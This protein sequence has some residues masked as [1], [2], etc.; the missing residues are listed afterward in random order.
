MALLSCFFLFFGF[1]IWEKKQKSFEIHTPAP[2]KKRHGTLKTSLEK[3]REHINN[4]QQ[5]F[6]LLGSMFCFFFGRGGV[7]VLYLPGVSYSIQNGSGPRQKK[8]KDG[9]SMATSCFGCE[10]NYGTDGI[11]RGWGRQAWWDPSADGWATN[12]TLLMLTL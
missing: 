4:F 1:Q 5:F 10:G 12:M 6:R 9:G 11:N 2:K 8:P 3:D 7:V